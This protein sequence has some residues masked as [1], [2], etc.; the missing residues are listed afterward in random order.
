M[1]NRINQAA[2]IIAILVILAWNYRRYTNNKLVER[3]ETDK[4][5]VLNK[6]KS[7]E[8]LKPVLIM[9]SV[10]KLTQD[11]SVTQQAFDLATANKREELTKLVEAL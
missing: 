5:Y 10:S 3:Y 8:E 6:I 4:E 7:G 9:V 1:K 2:L 11:Q